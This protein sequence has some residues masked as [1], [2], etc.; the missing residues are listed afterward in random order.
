MP[1]LKGTISGSIKSTAYSI[2]CTIKSIGIWNRSGGAIVANLGI[3]DE[4]GTDIYFK[5]Y[6]LAAV[7]SANSSDLAKT[8]I[9]VLANWR[10]LVATSGEC[11]YYISISE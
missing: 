8:D 3:T 11:D 10:I 6:N 9:K 4:N 5:A 2:P 1:V 7:G